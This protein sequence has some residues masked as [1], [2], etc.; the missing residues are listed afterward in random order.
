VSYAGIDPILDR[1]AAANGLTVMTSYKDYEV[2]S[3][4]LVDAQG[5]RF[6]LWLDP[7]GETGAV[8]VHVWDY[9]KRRADYEVQLEDLAEYLDGALQTASEWAGAELARR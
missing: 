1:W 3:I 9:R 2:R 7:P 5:T 4:D 8:G 6:Q